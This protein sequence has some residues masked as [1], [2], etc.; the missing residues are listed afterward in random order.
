MSTTIAQHWDAKYLISFL[1]YFL[2]DS[3]FVVNQE[4]ETVVK[5]N[6][7]ELLVNV[8]FSSPEEKENII[9]EVQTVSKQ[10]D[11]Q[12][13]MDL[14]E[15]LSARVDI[16]WN[17]YEYVVNELNEIAK[18]DNKVSVEEHALLYYIRLKLNRDYPNRSKK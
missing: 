18:A 8:F 11:E 9:T 6:I 10:L 3:D 7:H 17:V 12:Q 16:P 1:Y 15:Q 13:K 5:R 2:A 14:I 4:E